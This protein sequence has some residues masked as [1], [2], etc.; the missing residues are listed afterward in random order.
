MVACQPAVLAEVP[1]LGRYVFFSVASV[2]VDLVR[3]A[4]TRL[5]ALADGTQVLVGLGPE[6][7]Q[8]LGA[9]VP[10]LR[11]FTALSGPGVLVPATPS[12]LC[13]WLRGDDLGDLMHLTRRLQ[14]ALAPGLTLDQVIDGF[15]HGLGPQGHGLD[16]TG[17]EDGLENPVDDA[18][19][20]AALV[21]GA[22]PGLDGSSF[23]VV[24]QWRHNLDAFEAMSPEQQDHTVG[25]RRSDS[26]ELD[27]APESAHVKRTAQESFSPEAFV[28]RRSMPWVQGEQAGLVFVAFGR[29]FDAFEAQMRRMAGLDDGLVDAMFAISRPVT[30]AHFWCPP[31]LGGRLDLRQVG[32]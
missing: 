14:Q 12:A 21:Q 1:K 27:D 28:L 6:L 32:L 7:V 2:S 10:G 5:A 26:E 30:G 17:Y 31:V 18:A 8:L 24:Q 3:S 13:C 20:E 4:L 11:A 9:E 23:M 19:L 15:R 22:G 29:S 16:L 25:R